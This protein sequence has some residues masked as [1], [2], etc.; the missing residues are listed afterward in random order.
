MPQAG[1][2]IL[3]LAGVGLV[4]ARPLR[5]AF[6][7]LLVYWLLVPASLIF[8][9]GPH[10]VL[11]DRVVLYAFAVRLVLRVGRPGNPSPRAFRLTAVHFA[12]AGVLVAGYVDGVMLAA[13]GVSLA[14]D[15]DSWLYTLD[16]GVLFVVAL[17]V[18]R[19]IGAWPVIRTIAVVVGAAVV[20]GIIER[21]T[22]SGWSHFLF[23]HVPASYLAPGAAPLGSRGG[24]VRAQAAAQFSLEYA[25]VL[26]MLLPLVTVAALTWA[27]GAHRW[28]RLVV[29]LPVGVVAGVALTASRS[30][31]VGLAGVAVVLV[32]A[33]GAPRRLTGAVAAGLGT[34]L[35]LSLVIP[36]LLG[37]PFSAAAHSDSVSVRLQRLP[38]IFA[39]VVHRPFTGLGYAGLFGSVAGLDNS[40]ALLYATVGVLGLA[41]WAFML[42]TTAATVARTLRAPRG[43]DTRAL[44]SACLVGI[45]AV[46]VAGAAYDLVATPQSQ[47]TFMLLAALGVAVAEPVPRRV[48]PRRWW[49]ARALLPVAGVTAGVA[50]LVAVPTTS[51]ETVTVFMGSPAVVASNPVPVDDYTGKVLVNSLCGFLDSPD[52]VLAGTTLRCQRL[53]D[54]VSSAWP[55]LTLVRISGPSPGAV[56]AEFDNALGQYA[57][58]LPGEIA[59]V[60]PVVSGKPAWAT[61]APVWVG[62]VGL[63]AMFLIPPLSRRPLSARPPPAQPSTKR[64]PRR[65]RGRV[66]PRA[67]RRPSGRRTPVPEPAA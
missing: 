60:G 47:W 48:P 14:S 37:S 1:I 7:T 66:I 61:T 30:A 65:S 16:M 63:V 13:H 67:D 21:L 54:V 4:F 43:S 8:P 62:L 24:H 52:R 11:V 56:R 41:A 22:G 29:L 6:A 18:I 12:M 38:D 35:L 26:V 9:G 34:I 55:T 15:I 40:Y 46:L 59:P 3:A 28:A 50:M 53:S 23:E 39:L 64:A 20:V 17:A 45:V 44:G 49:T 36:T 57:P 5:V 27:R 33:S 42:I 25:W 31:E 10:I 19:T 32:I 58:Y 2:I 51:S